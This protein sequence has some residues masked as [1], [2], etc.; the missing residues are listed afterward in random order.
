M[1]KKKKNLRSSKFASGVTWFGPLHQ[2]CAISS[3]E[4]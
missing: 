2:M 4:G 1:L 3:G